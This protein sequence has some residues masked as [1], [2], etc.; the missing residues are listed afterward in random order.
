MAV[1]SKTGIYQGDLVDFM[2]AVMTLVNELRSDHATFGSSVSALRLKV[3]SITIALSQVTSIATSQPF[4][5]AAMDAAP[6]TL[7]ASAVSFTI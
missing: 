4:S 2:S 7:T 5:V 6:A 3:Q 1:I